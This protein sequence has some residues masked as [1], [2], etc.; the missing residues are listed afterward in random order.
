MRS[1]CSARWWRGAAGE[2]TCGGVADRKADQKD[3]VSCHFENYL[4][5]FFE[6]YLIPL[7]GPRAPQSFR[8]GL[9][10]TLIA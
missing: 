10:L 8:I 7:A 4:I 5:G 1:I 3:A 2:G 9:C 6:R